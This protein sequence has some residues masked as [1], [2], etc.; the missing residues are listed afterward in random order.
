[1]KNDKSIRVTQI[2]VRICYFLL[3][4][5]AVAFP[6]L[7]DYDLAEFEVLSEIKMQALPTFYCVVPA[8]YV[9]L[10]CLDK[11]L[12]NCKNSV[13][14]DYKNVKLL[15]IIS[16]ACFYAGAV[17]LITFVALLFSG[18]VFETMI[19]LSAGEFFMFLVVKVVKFILQSAVEIKEENDLTV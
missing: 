19:V 3:G 1:M 16:W 5:A 12:S 7:I 10:V 8:G 9:A 14:F 13:V 6:F 17:G 18:T 2:A 15:N 4:G 11:L